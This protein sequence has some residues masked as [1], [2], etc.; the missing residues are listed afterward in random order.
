[1]NEQMHRIRESIHIHH[2]YYTDL[3]YQKTL[4]STVMVCVCVCVYSKFDVIVVVVISFSS[5]FAYS[6]PSFSF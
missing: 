5:T 1:M 2:E 6:F 4:D 3:R